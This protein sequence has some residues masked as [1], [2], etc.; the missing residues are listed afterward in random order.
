MLDLLEEMGVD[1]AFKSGLFDCLDS[2]RSGELKVEEL[3]SGLM[4]LRGPTEKCDTVATL[5]CVRHQAEMI[6]DI[7]ASLCRDD[8]NMRF[9]FSKLRSNKAAESS[10]LG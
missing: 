1:T 5:L 6:S 9:S 10:M 4:T 2:D 8:T 7:H 3:I